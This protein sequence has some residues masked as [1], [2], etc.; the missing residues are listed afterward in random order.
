MVIRK[1]KDGALKVKQEARNHTVTAISAAFA[2]VI[3][4]VWRDAIRKALDAIVLKL[5]LPETAYIHEFVIAGILTVVCVIG[6]LVVSK[7]SIKE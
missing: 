7:F 2:F 3:A 4:L 5:K 1:L 6:I